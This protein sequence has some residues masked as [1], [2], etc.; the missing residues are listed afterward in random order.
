MTM[1]IMQLKPFKIDVSYHKPPEVWLFT[2]NKSLSSV[3]PHTIFPTNHFQGS[4]STYNFSNIF[5]RNLCHLYSPWIKINWIIPLLICKI[6]IT[7][8]VCFTHFISKAKIV[9]YKHNMIRKPQDVATKI[10]VM[11]YCSYPPL[12]CL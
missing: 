12:S 6:A 4:W 1:K 11:R 7:Y 10:F 3:S 5:Y 9:A 2:R 8:C